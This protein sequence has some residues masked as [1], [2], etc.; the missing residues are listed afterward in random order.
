M[1]D[2]LSCLRNEYKLKPQVV[3]ADGFFSTDKIIKRLVDYGWPLVFRW[4][5]NR[6]LNNTRIK[7]LIPR[8]YGDFQGYLKNGTKV[9]IFRRRNRFYETNRMLM[10]MQN[11]VK[12]YKSRWIIEETF[13]ILKVCIGLKRCQQHSITLQELFIYCCF[14]ALFLVINNLNKF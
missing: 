8:G 14:V 13:R 11:I 9:K 12:L 4:K 3:L 7:E 5:S 6:K 1:L 10:T 2:C